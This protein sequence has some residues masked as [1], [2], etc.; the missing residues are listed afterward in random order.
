MISLIQKLRKSRNAPFQQLQSKLLY[1]NRANQLADLIFSC[2][3]QGVANDKYGNEKIIVSLTTYGKRIYDVALSIES[4]MQGSM[5]PNKIILWIDKSWKGKGLPLALQRQQ[6]R[7]LE[8]NFCKD[9]RSYTK[10][11]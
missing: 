9:I 1:E 7:G 8:I 4:I 5:K 2:N 3:C 6:S 10:L 11:V